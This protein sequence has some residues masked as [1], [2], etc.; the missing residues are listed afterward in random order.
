MACPR[1]SDSKLNR[2]DIISGTAFFVLTCRNCPPIPLGQHRRV[3]PCRCV[4]QLRGPPGGLT[5][6]DSSWQGFLRQIDEHRNTTGRILS[7]R[8]RPRY[9]GCHKMCPIRHGSDEICVLDLASAVI[10]SGSCWPPFGLWFL[11]THA[12]RHGEFFLA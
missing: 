3:Y 6:T 10:E 2:G 11:E 9:C 12:R 5:Q 8:T 4:C 1:I 7:P